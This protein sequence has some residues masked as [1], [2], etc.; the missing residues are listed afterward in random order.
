MRFGLDVNQ[1]H[2]EWPD[3]L[4][5]TRFAEDAGFEGVWLFDHFQPL[6]GGSVGSCMEGWTLLAGLAAAT[7]RIRLGLL[8]TGVTYRHPSILA[9][10]VATV[11]NISNGRLEFGIGAAWYQ[12]EHT[13]LGVDFPSN[14][15]RAERLEEC[16]EVV[17]ALMTG[18]EVTFE[19][20]HYQLE[21]ATFMPRP[22]QRPNPP[23][24]IGAGGEKITLPIVGRQADYWHSFGSAG[25]IARKWQIVEAAAVKA[26]RDPASIG[27]STSLS[28]SA[29][30]DTIRHDIE[31]FALAGVS[32]LVVSWPTEGIEKIESFVA[33]VMTEFA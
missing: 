10:E 17:R 29:S 33:D 27:I 8:V 9:A 15:E 32:Y 22:I 30:H 19:G 14:R 7:T 4:D 18:D 12:K 25:D 28:L 5:R 23:V 26:G 16:V 21:G 2:L 3:I 11:D 20:R 13:E 1:H 24:W 31:E 6:Y